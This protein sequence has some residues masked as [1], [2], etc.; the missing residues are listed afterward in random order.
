MEPNKI[1]CNNPNCSESAVW[2]L[3]RHV[4]M[5]TIHV[6]EA[7]FEHEKSKLGYIEAVKVKRG[8]R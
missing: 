7:C 6:C 4:D 8:A 2:A 1:Y 5:K 3:T